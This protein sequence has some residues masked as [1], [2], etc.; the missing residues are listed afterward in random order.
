MQVSRIPLFFLVFLVGNGLAAQNFQMAGIGYAN[1]AKTN[2]KESSSNESVKF[3]EFS[4]FAKLPIKFKNQKTLLMNTARYGL[5]QATNYHS[6]LFVEDENTKNLHSV[7]WSMALI[8]NLNQ[9]WT[10]IAVLTPTLASDFEEK[11]SSDDFLFQ[12]TLLLSRKLNDKWTLGG[13]AVYTTQLGTPQFLP[14]VQLRYANEKHFISVLLPSVANYLYRIDEKQKWHVGF[15][16]ATNGGNF[17][18][19]NHDFTEVIPNSIDKL[20]YSRVNLGP[21]VN[22]QLTKSLQLEVFGGMSAGRK[23]KL[24]AA[25]KVFTNYNAENGGFFNLSLFVTPPAKTPAANAVPEN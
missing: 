9:K 14:A 10:V 3:Q 19:N 15:R 20:I 8:Q 23:Y 13:G 4:F 6:P 2:I 21:V 7:S 16:L 25:S 24:E 12:G 5:V 11:L 18:V 22:Y 17:N 1:Y